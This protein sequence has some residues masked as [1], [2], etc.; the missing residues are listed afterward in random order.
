MG[1]LCGICVNGEWFYNW[2]KETAANL[3]GMLSK[4][5]Y[6]NNFPVGDGKVKTGLDV[7]LVVRRGPW[8]IV[9]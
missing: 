1:N 8:L 7:L 4:L 6:L 5:G 3:G 9:C 2:F